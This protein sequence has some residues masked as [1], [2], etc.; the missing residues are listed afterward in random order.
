VRV[1][2][3]I[4]ADDADQLML[5]SFYRW[6]SRDQDVRRYA[7]VS[8]APSGSAGEMGGLDT[9]NILL[10]QGISL[11]NLAIAFAAWRDSRAKSSTI[12]VTVGDLSVTLS[13]ESP[14]MAQSRIQVLLSEISSEPSEETEA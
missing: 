5:N 13:D 6:L 3:D 1:S 7:S 14:E 9:I 4:P 10:T 12:R 2:I 8:L 11:L